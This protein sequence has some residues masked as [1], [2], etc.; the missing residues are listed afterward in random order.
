MVDIVDHIYL[1]SVLP[2]ALASKSFRSGAQAVRIDFANSL[3]VVS[4]TILRDP[5]LS[6]QLLSIKFDGSVNLLL[7]QL[8]SAISYMP[9]DV[10]RA[11]QNTAS[12]STAAVKADLIATNLNRIKTLMSTTLTNLVGSIGDELSKIFSTGSILQSR[13]DI[14]NAFTMFN[15]LSS[16]FKTKG[17]MYDPQALPD[18]Y[19]ATIQ[20]ALDLHKSGIQS[21]AA[22]SWGVWATDLSQASIKTLTETLVTL[23]R[24][25]QVGNDNQY[26]TSASSGCDTA[27]SDFRQKL[28]NEYLWSDKQ[29][30]KDL[31]TTAADN[32]MAAQKAIWLKNKVSTA[33]ASK[34]G[35]HFDVFVSEK[36]SNFVNTYNT[37]CDTYKAYITAELAG[38]VPLIIQS[39]RDQLD[40]IDLNLD[41]P[42]TTRVQII[43]LSNAAV[44]IAKNK[45]TLAK[46]N[47]HALPNG[48]IS[49]TKIQTYQSQLD[50]GLELDRKA[51]VDKYDEVVSVYNQALLSEIIIPITDQ[52]L[53]NNFISTSA[54]DTK[55]T[56]QLMLFMSKKKGEEEL[57]L[58]KWNEWKTRTYPALVEVVQ[59]NNS[60]K[61]DGLDGNLAAIKAIQEHVV[62]NI[63]INCSGLA[64]ELGMSYI[65]AWTLSDVKPQDMGMSVTDPTK[66]NQQNSRIF[67]LNNTP[68]NGYYDVNNSTNIEFFDWVVE[69]SDIIWCKPIITDL[70]PLKLDTTE[71]PAQNTPIT[72]TVGASS[73]VTSTI[74]DSQSWGVNAGVEVGYKLGVNDSWQANLK[75][76]FNGNFSSMKSRSE[77]TTYTSTT[78][79]QLTLSA[80]CVNCVNQKVFVQKTSLPYTA[81][82][83]VVPRLRFQNG[84]TIWDCS[85]HQSTFEFRRTDEIRDDALANADPWEWKLAM[86]RS[87]YLVNYLDN[88]TTASQ[89]EFYVKGKW[90][91]ITGKY[92]VT[93]VTPKNTMTTLLPPS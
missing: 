20:S 65:G 17:D 55:I 37:A 24:N 45:F 73:A 57:A 7:S 39:C 51:K 50:I 14:N 89:Y 44:T 80:N 47:L 82:V 87:S 15:T 25:T 40:L 54:L 79:A 63:K 74:T 46:G 92:A 62:D 10:V 77:S 86:E 29:D 31:F 18:K 71:Y 21:K 56:T 69:V 1:V 13:T 26:N 64:S 8:A 9:V 61:V 36:K 48:A 2:M 90:E 22:S 60:Y 72:V 27:K 32:T 5:N 76:T 33:L 16:T 23:G 53:A 78:S 42:T 4:D 85:D 35:M 3:S 6:T 66:P 93:T 75:A 84:Y 91:G 83:K 34:F 19:E 38:Q 49:S 81:K 70:K 30:K 58:A 28:D 11:A 68:R 52:T 67:R 88:L 59:R 12:N 43:L 41:L